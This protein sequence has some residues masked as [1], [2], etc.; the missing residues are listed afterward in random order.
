MSDPDREQ[1]G[2][3]LA[4]R[5]LLVLT[6]IFIVGCGVAGLMEIRAEA[7][8]V[9][10]ARTIRQRPS[11][12]AEPMFPTPAPR[13]SAGGTPACVNSSNSS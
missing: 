6:V 11:E 7:R 10:P 12:P 3:R 2:G 1:R 13:S 4:I 9:T 5:F 8:S